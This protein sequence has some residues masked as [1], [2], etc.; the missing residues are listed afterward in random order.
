MYT[1]PCARPGGNRPTVA[2]R[3]L[4]NVEKRIR[5]CNRFGTYESEASGE[6]E[7]VAHHSA[8]SDDDELENEEEMTG[9]KK[10][11]AKLALKDFVEVEEWDWM[12]FH[13]GNE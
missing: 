12:E 9:G 13:H 7:E 5:S 6:E 4:F 10:K 2:R 3:A 11:R 1:S 8:E